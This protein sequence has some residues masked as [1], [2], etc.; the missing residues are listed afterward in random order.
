[1][2][3]RTLS[4]NMT[5]IKITGIP[6]SF[7]STRISVATQHDPH[8]A[9]ILHRYKHLTQ[10]IKPTDAGDH[11]TQHHIK[12]TGQPA[13]SRPRRLPPH[14]LAYAKKAT[15][16]TRPIFRRHHTQPNHCKSFPQE[17]RHK[18]AQLKYTPPRQSS[19]AIHVP[20]QLQDCEFIFVRNDAVKKP[21]TPTYQGPFKVLKRSE[22]HLTIDRGSRTDTISIDRVKPA[23]L[24]KSPRETEP[25]STHPRNRNRQNRGRSQSQN[26]P[27]LHLSR[28]VLEGNQVDPAQQLSGPSS[29]S[30]SCSNSPFSGLTSECHSITTLRGSTQ[31]TPAPSSAPAPSSSLLH[32]PALLQLPALLHLPAF[33]Q[34]PTLLQLPAVS[35]SPLR[36]STDVPRLFQHPLTTLSSAH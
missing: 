1:M 2:K 20:Q 23:F 9:E 6:S 5:T 3:T 16:F 10:P 18:M 26:H 15:L 36:R 33:L 32:L 19:P 24:E 25:V 8:Y 7:N 30:S 4:D 17:L 22:K 28:P 29:S 21:L 14:K 35:S 11:Q 34:L 27:S 13:Y 12:T 31:L